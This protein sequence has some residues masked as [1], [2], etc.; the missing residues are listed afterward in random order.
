MGQLVEGATS[1]PFLALSSFVGR[2]RDVAEVRRLLS[3]SRLV[4]LTG[5]GGVGKTRLALE[6]ANAVRRL[7]PDGLVVVELDQVSDPALVVNKVAVSVGLREQ[8]G[9][10]PL[11]MLTDYLA[12]RQLLLVLDNSEHVIDAIAD[13]ADALLQA[14]PHL[15]I[16]ATSREWLGIAGE[17]IM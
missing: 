17:V 1:G 8:A 6:V 2:A 7:F 16:L 11:E 4:T 10:A 15:R 12:S 5:P 14:C 3:T 13:L 9:R